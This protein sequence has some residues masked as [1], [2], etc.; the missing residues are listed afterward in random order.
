MTPR[1]VLV[2]TDWWTDCDDVAALRV[3]VWAEKQRM[4]DVLAIGINA[5]MEYSV[6]SLDAFLQEE[7]RLG[8][9]IGID[10]EAT[11]FGGNPPYQKNM[12]ARSQSSRTNA[13]CEDAVRVYRRSLAHAEDKMDVIEIG[14]PQVLANLLR[15]PEDDISPLAGLELVSGKVN[16]LWMMAGN[17]GD[18]GSGVENNF[19]RNLRSRVAGA[20]LCEHWPTPITFL[21]WE[22]A[23][24]IRT[25]GTLT[26][27]D[28]M[29][30]QA[31]RDHGS[32]EGRSSWDPM[33]V[34]LACL[35]DET[36]AGYRT[37]TGTASVDK[38]TGRNSF[39][40]HP[41]GKH[42]YVIKTKLDDDYKEAINN[43]LES[44]QKA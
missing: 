11:D 25:G 23:D 3:L 31:M 16:K 37:V 7:G 10:H 19:A 18:Q 22:V 38:Q 36:E 21:G 42:R 29:V 20:Y 44:M 1:A 35:G 15:S 33:L 41:R 14:Y 8:V 12:A 28:D 5:C 34:L 26:S 24:S 17:W 4:I 13:D 39:E 6:M 27:S 2:G 40:V 43:I 32:S 9:T 30:A